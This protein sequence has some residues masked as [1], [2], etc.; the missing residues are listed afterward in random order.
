MV[1][2][3]KQEMIEFFTKNLSVEVMEKETRH[4]YYKHEARKNVEVVESGS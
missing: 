1:N 3:T 4:I 2:P